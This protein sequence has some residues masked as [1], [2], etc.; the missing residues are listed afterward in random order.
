M[1]RY[2]YIKNGIEKYQKLVWK[3]IQTFIK[4]VHKKSKVENC[5]KCNW[6]YIYHLLVI[7]IKT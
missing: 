2:C 1:Y 3:R 5:I 4:D 7:W 6:G